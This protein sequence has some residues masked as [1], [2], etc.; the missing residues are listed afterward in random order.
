M[1]V[2]DFPLI[3]GTYETPSIQFSNQ[4]VDTCSQVRDIAEFKQGARA[5]GKEDTARRSRYRIEAIKE[6]N[7]FVQRP[8]ETVRPKIES[9]C[10]WLKH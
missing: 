4:S 6:T 8:E 3:R 10:S 2:L 1:I 9:V 5:G 7:L